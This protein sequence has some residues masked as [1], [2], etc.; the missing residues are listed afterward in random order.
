MPLTI[1]AQAKKD[2]CIAGC[3]RSF[4]G[5]PKDAYRDSPACDPFGMKKEVVEDGQE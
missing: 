5:L 3:G 4:H 2:P 1:P